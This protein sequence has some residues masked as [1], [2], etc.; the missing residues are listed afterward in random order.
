MRLILIRDFQGLHYY[1]YIPET[2]NARKE[3]IEVFELNKEDEDL[4]DKD[5]V[6]SVDDL[7]HSLIDPGD[8]DFLNADQCRLLLGWL[9]ERLKDPL[10]PR[11]EIIYNVLVRFVQKAIELD[12]GIVFDL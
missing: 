7:C 1:G 5:F 6:T 10:E 8:V 12:T 11:L 9:R 3:Q 4:L 2:N